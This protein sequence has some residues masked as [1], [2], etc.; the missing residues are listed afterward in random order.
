MSH[1]PEV[2]ADGSVGLLGDAHGNL[3]FILSALVALTEAQPGIR[4]VWQLGDA[5]LV[6]SGHPSERA[7]IAR[8]DSL[9][10]MLGIDQLGCVLGNHEGYGVLAHRESDAVGRIWLSPRIFYF[11]HGYRMT[12]PAGVAI[13]VLGGA[14]SPDRSIRTPGRSWWPEE[15]PD[16]DTLHAFAQGGPVDILLAHDAPRS[17]ALTATLTSGA[18]SDSGIAY[19][20]RIQDRFQN[21]AAEAMS[22]RG[23]ILSGHYHQRVSTTT[24]IHDAEGRAVTVRSEVLAA[25]TQSGSVAVL[26]LGTQQLRDVVLL[27]PPVAR[28]RTRVLREVLRGR[29]SE[30]DIAARLGVTT[31]Q[32]RQLRSG[33][34]PVW[35]GILE[36]SQALDGDEE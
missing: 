22:D 12:T 23:L 33:H 17:A 29:A 35:S 16:D 7:K 32:L 26:N 27:D 13:A 19:A 18:F 34:L 36:R 1:E 10:E 2:V 4:R 21:A 8:I 6:W 28:K 20:T 14:G 25:E 15:A 3:D 24:E 31:R 11:P 9:L 5:G 30:R